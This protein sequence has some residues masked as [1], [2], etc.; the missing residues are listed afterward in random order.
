VDLWS[1]LKKV[2]KR[3]SWLRLLADVITS[4]TQS[5]V[6]FTTEWSAV[7]FPAG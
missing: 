7:R 4:K 1:F 3:R 6:G 2:V 5:C